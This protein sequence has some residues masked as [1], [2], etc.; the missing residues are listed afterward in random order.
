MRPYQLL[1]SQVCTS[2]EDFLEKLSP[3][4][5]FFRDAD[6]DAPWFFRGQGRPYDLIPSALRK[7]PSTGKYPIEEL[8]GF[9]FDSYDHRIAAQMRLLHDFF[10]IS[11]QHGLVLPEDTQSV[12]SLFEIYENDRATEFGGEWLDNNRELLSPLALAQHYGLPTFLLD[13]SYNAFTAAY[14]AA[15]DAI[16]IAKKRDAEQKI[17]QTAIEKYISVLKQSV[18][19]SILDDALA[20]LNT[21]SV[22]DELVVWALYY[23]PLGTI[24]AIGSNE[25]FLI[26]TAPSATNPNLHAQQGVFTWPNPTY[27]LKTDND[28]LPF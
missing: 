24:D 28:L 6:V 23:P 1:Q 19:K 5:T 9:P 15:Q 3:L 12:R 7:N 18:D 22:A 16:T 10:R 27:C 20:Q 14:F 13:W 2:A 25:A 26:A 21:T 8:I 11:D 4:G 17:R